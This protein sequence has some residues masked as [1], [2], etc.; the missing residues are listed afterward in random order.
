MRASKTNG[1][2]I[3]RLKGFDNKNPVLFNKMYKVCKPYIR[4]LAKNIDPKKYNVTSDII[5]DYFW[6][7]FMYVYA[8]YYHECIEVSAN[9]DK[10]KHTLLHSLGCFKNKLLRNAYT[11]QA[12][13]N[14]TL[15]PFDNLFNDSD[16]NESDD[17]EDEVVDN[18]LGLVDESTS[19]T[20]SQMEELMNYLNGVLTPDEVLLFQTELNPPEFFRKD[21]GGFKVTIMD[22][23]DFFELPRNTTS[24]NMISDMR[25]H[26]RL[27]I[28]EAK[29]HF[30]RN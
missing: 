17:E 10:L 15:V 23:I 29:I 21:N 12:E 30:H 16:R 3:H 9:E 14:S 20:S 4:N 13:F 7:K 5:R 2:E 27:A 11:K 28:E 19:Q 26:I 18:G 24:Y 6:D 22:L 8:K 25:K 1:C